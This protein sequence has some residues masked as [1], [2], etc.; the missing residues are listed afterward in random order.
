MLKPKNKNRNSEIRVIPIKECLAKTTKNKP[1]VS[2]ETHCRIIGYIARELLSR[3]PE[4]LRKS[5]FPR[6]SELI[7]AAHDVGKVSPTFQEKIYK[8]IGK[9]L[10]LI[11]PDLDKEIGYHYAVSQATV[12]QCPKY[13]PEILGRHHGYTPFGIHMPE[14]EVYGGQSWQKQRMDL[15][16]FLKKDLNVDWPIIPSALHSDVIAGLTTVADW[17][18]SGP[19]FDG[20][21]KDGY[22]T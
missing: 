22:P 5:L 7:A 6:G 20:V 14:A 18:G 10:G 1:G 16:N 15:L 9:C 2:V 17:I 19:L 3:L 8:D 21:D 11:N 13:I 12:R 4:W